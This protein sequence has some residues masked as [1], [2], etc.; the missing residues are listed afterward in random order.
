L[1]Q[2]QKTLAEV[3]KIK[4][5]AQKLATE[6]DPATVQ[7]ERD[8]ET[9]K[10]VMENE[11]ERMKVEIARLQ[12]EVAQVKALSELEGERE[13]TRATIEAPRREGASVAP[14]VVVDRDGK[15]ADV[16]QPTVEAMTLALAQTSEALEA[17]SET[18][19]SLLQEMVAMKGAANRPRNTRLK[20]V[21]RP[22]GS[23]EGERI[24]D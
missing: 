19:S 8:F 16:I 14:M 3:E 10:L 13:R 17:L 1:S 4:A 7:L 23:Y 20:V 21:K 6:Y 24:E 9:Q 18:Q 12:A 15:M 5:E 2:A 22:D 11:K